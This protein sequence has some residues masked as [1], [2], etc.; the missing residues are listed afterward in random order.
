MGLQGLVSQRNGNEGRSFSWSSLG[1]GAG[2]GVEVPGY[3]G[4]N[5]VPALR[6]QI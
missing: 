3:M 5:M 1:A 6:Q 4:R 2:S